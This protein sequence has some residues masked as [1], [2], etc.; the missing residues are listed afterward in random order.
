MAD[1]SEHKH[2]QFLSTQKYLALLDMHFWE[3]TRSFQG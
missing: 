3:L 1:I 2:E